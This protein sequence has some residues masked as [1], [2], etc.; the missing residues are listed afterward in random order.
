MTVRREHDN[1]SIDSSATGNS[2][3]FP[4]RGTTHV[5]ASIINSGGTHV[6]NK[7]VLQLSPNGTDWFNFGLGG[8]VSGEKETRTEI[9]VYK[10]GRFR[11]TTGE[12]GVS[13]YNGY[14]WAT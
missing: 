2:A 5:T 11:V 12:G 13:S 7:V 6:A 8:A 10:R 14:I 3:D 1:I 4:L 9:G